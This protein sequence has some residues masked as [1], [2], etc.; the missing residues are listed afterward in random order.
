MKMTK[1]ILALALTLVMALSLAACG[2]KSNANAN[3]N[4]ETK[5]E[6]TTE[7]TETPETVTNDIVVASASLGSTL[8]PWDQV[9]GTT[10]AFQYATY[11]YLVKYPTI[12][13]ENGNLVA[14]T[15]NVVGSLAE[16]WDVNEEQTEWTFYLNPNATFANGDKV[17]AEDVVWSFTNCRENANS[18]F[19]FTLTNIDT[20]EVIDE[21]TVKFTLTHKSNM[22]LRLLE[23]YNFAVVNKDEAEAAIASDPDYLT[24]HTAGSGPYTIETYDTTSE[25]KFVAREDYW[26][27]EGKA[28]NNSVTWKLV[29]EPSD[30]QLLLQN[31]DVDIALDLEDKNISTVAEMEGVNV[32]QFAS[33]KHLF[34]CLNSEVE[35]FNNPK[36]R[37][38]IAYAIPYDDLVNEVMYGNAVRTT[39]M[40][41]DNVSGH[42]SIEGETYVNQDLE[43]AKALLAEAGYPDGFSCEMTLGNGFT[44]WE[45]SAV[46]IQYALSQIGIDM[47]INEIDRA[48]F[49]TEAAGLQIPIFLN[50][51]N[52]FIGDPGYLCNCLFTSEAS[53]NY[54]NFHNDEFDALYEKAET[55]TSEEERLACY[56]E[57]QYI[58]G[59]ENPV[60]ELYQYGWAYCGRDN[61]SGFRFSPDLTLRFP[62]LVKG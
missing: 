45:E 36:V 1:R 23:I 42:I 4:T 17:T 24:T 25:V 27:E 56:E 5:T 11:D 51:F 19:F 60:I 61:V 26:N 7:T 55:A 48:A 20:M 3:A 28:Q 22:F 49:L 16:R 41:P 54:Y 43:K 50:R 10:S 38:A 62:N 12:T 6:E 15:S 52:P 32:L 9:D 14:D 21:T 18:S 37:E 31:G 44:D 57:M 8:N 34:L 39:S 2:G 40:L 35:P 13:D 47:K 33:N 29:Q 53:Y 30:R 59:D 46:T 58:F